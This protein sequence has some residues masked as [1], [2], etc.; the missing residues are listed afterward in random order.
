MVEGKNGSTIQRTIKQTF[1]PEPSALV[2]YDF[3]PVTD[4]LEVVTYAYKA[5]IKRRSGFVGSDGNHRT[6]GQSLKGADLRELLP[7]LAKYKVGARLVLGGV[8]RNGQRLV[9][10]S[11]KG[12][13]GARS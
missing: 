3:A 5:V 1:P 10:T 11:R 4:P 2:P 8:R 7:F 6:K 13:P 9:F 12:S